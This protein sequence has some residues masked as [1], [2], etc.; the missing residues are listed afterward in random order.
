MSAEGNS[1]DIISDD[2]SGNIFTIKSEDGAEI[3][4]EIDEENQLVING[5]VY[6]EVDDDALNFSINDG[7]LSILHNGKTLEGYTPID[8][9][10]NATMTPGFDDVQGN[11]Q[12]GRFEINGETIQANNPNEQELLSNYAEIQDSVAAAP[13][14][15]TIPAYNSA[16]GSNFQG[17]MT[18][19][20]YL[21]TLMGQ[22]AF[23]I[24][25]QK[26]QYGGYDSSDVSTLTDWEDVLATGTVRENEDGSITL[27][28][29]AE[30]PRV[31]FYPDDN[32]AGGRTPTQVSDLQDVAFGF[33][34]DGW[35]QGEAAWIYEL[36]NVGDGQ[37][38][39]IGFNEEGNLM[40]A[41][42]NTDE[43]EISLVDAAGV[44]IDYSNGAANVSVLNQDGSVRGTESIQINTDEVHVK[45]I[46][47]Y[48]RRSAADTELS[49]TF[50]QISFG[51]NTV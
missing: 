32:A 51:N 19:K 42:G 25:Q 1:L 5:K 24:E 11:A 7:Q 36:H 20:D 49:A 38:M 50:N 29:S 18:F 9:G 17:D 22:D 21:S 31:Q 35:S 13:G 44:S 10:T 26:F 12:H 2:A 8:V 16:Q 47:L 46:E 43:T 34:I 6:A 4:A 15:D 3:S 48:N 37:A 30:T 33:S 14:T 45:G 41:N 28:S 39:A 40:L 27:S 23:G